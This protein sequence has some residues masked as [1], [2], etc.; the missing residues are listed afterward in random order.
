MLTGTILRREER[1]PPGLRR[2]WREKDIKH[3]EKDKKRAETPL[4]HPFP[5]PV[6]S[7]TNLSFLSKTGETD[8]KEEKFRA[9]GRMSDSE[10]GGQERLS[11]RLKASFLVKTVINL[12]LISQEC[13]ECPCS[14]R[15]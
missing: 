8:G 15:G 5:T 7:R 9:V 3:T 11:W 13:Q 12:S 10:T 2:D 6:P 1:L 4:S 14:Q